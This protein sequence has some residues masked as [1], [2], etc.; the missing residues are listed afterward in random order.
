MACVGRLPRA[1]SV[2][3][4]LTGA[5]VGQGRC[6]AQE[7][8]V[9]LIVITKELFTRESLRRTVQLSA[10]AGVYCMLERLSA[11][12]SMMRAILFGQTPRLTS[13]ALTRAS[14]GICITNNG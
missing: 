3:S 11:L 10:R 9:S 13:V 7:L 6:L 2:S 4:A 12:R 1:R 5:I 14:Q 8:S